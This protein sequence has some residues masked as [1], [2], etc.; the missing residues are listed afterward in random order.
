MVIW[1]LE[2]VSK[3]ST[4]EIGNLKENARARGRDDVVALCDQGFEPAE[5][6]EIRESFRMDGES[7][8][9]EP[10]ALEVARMIR[11]LEASDGKTRVR[12]RQQLRNHGVVETARRAVMSP[13]KRAHANLE[14]LLELG[15]ADLSFESLVIRF[16]SLFDRDTIAVA[17]DRL[18]QRMPLRQAA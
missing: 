16:S 13:S 17:A 12:T 9:V 11:A 6:R 4:Q 7:E 14:L 18:A 5:V 2:R 15:R 3:L 1:T 10:L 8:A